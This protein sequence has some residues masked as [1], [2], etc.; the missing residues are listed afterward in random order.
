MDQVVAD[1]AALDGCRSAMSSQA[2]RF[3]AIA[4]RFS[5]P[6]VDTTAFGR[7]PSS[8]QLASLATQLDE[9][10][11]AQFT[12]ASTLLGDVE[13]ALDAV[14]RAIEATEHANTS[15]INAIRV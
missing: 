1:L 13:R 8:N 7:L 14:M 15:Q 9:T 4:D 11:H 12:A 2:G 5:R 3:G 6:V 10:A